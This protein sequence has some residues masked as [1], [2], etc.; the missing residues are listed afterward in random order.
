MN[1]GSAAS[2]LAVALLAMLTLAPR[3]A[4]QVSGEPEGSAMNALSR[5]AVIDALLA[6]LTAEYVFPETAL[7]MSR[8]IRER[9]RRGEYDR[10]ASAEEFA[11]SLTAHL[12][13]VSRD[14]HLEVQY[15]SSR[16][17]EPRA[18]GPGADA[19]A[20][21]RAFGREVNFGFE[22]AAR[23][24]GNVGYI[25]VRT[26][27]YEPAWVEEAAAAAFLLVA[28]TDALIIDLRR[29]AGGSPYTV[30]F[31]ASY[32]FGEDSVQLSSLTWRDGRT[33]RFYTRRH[34][35]GRRY[36]AHKPV[37]ILTGRATFSGAEEFAYTLQTLKR[38]VIVGDT[39]LGGGH[40][41]VKRRVTDHFSMWLPSGRAVNPVTGKNWEGVGVPPDVPVPENQALRVAH[42]LA[43]RRLVATTPSA[44]RKRWLEEILAQLGA[45]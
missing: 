21:T 37:F 36:G 1:G 28:N 22:R 27:E 24:E 19:E 12:Q 32:L 2:H 43:L 23:L 45:P 41:G 9:E 39:T 35:P 25:D 4:A 31:V 40:P 3:S 44:V 5:G 7:A 26:F 15:T 14:R 34:V 16:L 17:P 6:R 38:A 29:N 20:L 11:E 30:A 42:I 8:A 13:A 33:E 10:L 18:G